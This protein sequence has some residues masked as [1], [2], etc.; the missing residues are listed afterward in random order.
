MSS[1]HG[2]EDGSLFI[3][4]RLT[5]PSDEI[6]L[7]VTTSGG[8]GGSARES[9]TDARRGVL[10][11]ERVPGPLERRPR[12]ALGKTWTGRS[13]E[14][15]SIPLA[16]T[17]SRCRARTVGPEDRRCVDPSA[18]ATR[19]QADEGFEGSS[20]RRQE[21]PKSSEGTAPS[22]YGRLADLVQVPGDRFQGR[23]NE[24]VESRVRVLV[25]PRSGVSDA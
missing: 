21:S 24:A 10:R 9:I 15:R 11:R 20:S 19:D 8:P 17:E 14:R 7:R 1:P 22:P 12:V 13:R 23:M 25:G 2:L 6:V 16:G 4:N 3:R 5:I 18:T